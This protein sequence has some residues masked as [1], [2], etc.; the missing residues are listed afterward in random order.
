[1]GTNRHAIIRYKALDE[2]FGNRYKEFA[3]S[4]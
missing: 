4:D 3:I 1:M 2:C